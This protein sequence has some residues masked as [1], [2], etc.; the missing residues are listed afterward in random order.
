MTKASI[1]ILACD[2]ED[3]LTNALESVRTQ[4]CPRDRVETIIVDQGST[5]ATPLKYVPIV[6]NSY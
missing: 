5:E 3:W 2:S 6:T 4:R 1:V